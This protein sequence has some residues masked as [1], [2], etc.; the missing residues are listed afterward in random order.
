MIQ[1]TK[2]SRWERFAVRMARQ[3]RKPTTYAGIMGAGGIAARYISPEHQLDI[4]YALMGLSYLILTFFS[5][6]DSLDEKP[7]K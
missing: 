7:K 6:T 3:L 1:K 2:P 5:D 4:M